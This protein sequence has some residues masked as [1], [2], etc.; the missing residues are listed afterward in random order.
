MVTAAEPER[1]LARVARP[2]I[3]VIDLHKSFGDH[4]VL[5]GINLAVPAGSTCVI[6]GGSGSGKT[7]LMK[8]MIGLLKPDQGQVIVDGEDIVPLGAESWS[9]CAASSAW[10]S[11]PRRSSTR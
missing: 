6:L 8:H 5:T 7:V 3:Q 9:G 11:R 2:M 4:Q 10:C 1:E